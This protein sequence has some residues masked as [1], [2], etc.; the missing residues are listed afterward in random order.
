MG[1]KIGGLRKNT[2]YKLSKGKRKR[3]K[4]SIIEYYKI[5]N[6][7]EMV[8]FLADPGIQKGMYHPRFHGKSGTVLKKR[9]KCYEIELIDGNLKKLMIVH[10]IH[11]RRFLYL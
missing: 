6:P 8:Y 1:T 9:G 5:L 7:G 11:L 3:G 4:I 2:R 10:P